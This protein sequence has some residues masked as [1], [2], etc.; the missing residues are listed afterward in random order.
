MG[1]FEKVVQRK[2][3]NANVLSKYFGLS[4]ISVHSLK[5]EK[6]RDR[7]RKRKNHYK[8]YTE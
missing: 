6:P 4:A 2:L 1:F 7:T 8:L 3:H 5:V